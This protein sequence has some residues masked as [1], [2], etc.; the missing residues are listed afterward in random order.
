MVVAAVLVLAL[1][2]LLVVIVVS[3]RVS[4]RWFAGTGLEEWRATSRA[5][6]LRDRRTIVWAQMRGRPVTDPRLTKAA[7]VRG[8]YAVAAGARMVQPGSPLRRLRWFLVGMAVLQIA[9][10][11]PRVVDGEAL[12]WFLLLTWFFNGALWL[13]YPRLQAHGLRRIQRS[14]DGTLASSG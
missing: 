8:R 9:L 3:V 6:S 4:R 13:G 12:G 14:V 11:L 5:L 10:A 2:L 7:L 1:A